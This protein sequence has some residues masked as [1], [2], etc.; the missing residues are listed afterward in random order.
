V[1][2]SSMRLLRVVLVM[3]ARSLDVAREEVVNAA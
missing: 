1:L 2:S 3:Y